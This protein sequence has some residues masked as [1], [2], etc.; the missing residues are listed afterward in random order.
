MTQ[1]HIFGP[2]LSRRLGLSLGIDLVPFKTCSYDCAYCE[3]GHTTSKTVTRQDFFPAEDVMTELHG[4]LTSRP[5]LDSITLAGS[6]EPTLARSLGPVI[7]FVKQEYPEYLMSVLTNGSLLTR[8]DVREELLP[9]DRVIPTLTTASK[10]IF[11]CIHNP[12][13]S[14]KIDTIINGMVQ[15]RSMYEGVIWLEVFVIPGLNTTDEE[16]AGLKAAIDQIDPDLVQLNTLDRPAAE[17]WVKAASGT[18]LQRVRRALG[19]PGIEIAGQ[20]LPVSPAAQAKTGLTDLIRATLCRRPSTVEDLVSTTG[21]SGGE[22]V[23]ILGA[24]ER[25]GEVT[26]QQGTRGVFYSICPAPEGREGL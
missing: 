23:K 24:L 10:Y 25:G 1:K 4:A 22:V 21:M 9:A 26:S 2:V 15:F 18:E 7:A 17:G 19:R 3:C 13:P 11:E 16:L 5:H 6:G 8:P 14:V 20:R 12:H